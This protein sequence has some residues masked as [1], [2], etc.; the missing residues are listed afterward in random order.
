MVAHVLL[1]FLELIL[2]QHAVVDEDAGKPVSQCTRHQYRRHRGI[3]AATQAADGAAFWPNLLLDLSD[4]LVYELLRS[5]V[6]ASAA[7]IEDKVAQQLRS[8]AGVM[9]FRMELYRPDLSRCVVE[10]GK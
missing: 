5:P 4:G 7:N 8:T 10:R 3:H 1:N 2:A 9:D 6:A